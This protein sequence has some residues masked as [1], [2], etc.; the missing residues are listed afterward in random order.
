[1]DEL[2]VLLQRAAG[3]AAAYRATLPDR[4]VAA[5]AGLDA[6]RQA[7]GGP[8]PPGPTPP[9]VVLDELVAAAEPGLVATAG[10]TSGS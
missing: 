6:L 8:L 4:P 9:Q 5:A 1:M 2:S 3:A 7:F 10:A